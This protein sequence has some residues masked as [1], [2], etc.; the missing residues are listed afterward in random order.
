MSALIR[1]L[2][3]ADGRAVVFAEEIAEWFQAFRRREIL[4]V[5]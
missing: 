3:W 5:N 4:P 1:V 2:D